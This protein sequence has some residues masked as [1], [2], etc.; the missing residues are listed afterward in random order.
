MDLLLRATHYPTGIFIQRCQARVRAAIYSPGSFLPNTVT[1]SGGCS[2]VYDLI[3]AEVRMPKPSRP[4]VFVLLGYE[5]QKFD[6]A[7]GLRITYGRPGDESEAND[8]RTPTFFLM[9]DEARELARDL[10]ELADQVQARRRG[11]TPHCTRCRCNPRRRCTDSACVQIARQPFARASSIR[12]R[13]IQARGD[14]VKWLFMQEPGG[15][16]W[17]LLDDA[18]HMLVYED[19]FQTA[20]A[21]VADA[22]RHGYVG[23][24]HDRPYWTAPW[25][26]S[27]RQRKG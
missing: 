15:W 8:R 27:E 26:G 14:D 6:E 21:A 20:A 13:G 4:R 9:P 19:G 18:D 23:P 16:R 22:K 10:V 17:E 24:L 1:E 5:L 11:Q 25:D 3:H 7:L 12:K 2:R